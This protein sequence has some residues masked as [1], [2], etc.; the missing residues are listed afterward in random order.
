MMGEMS[1]VSHLSWTSMFCTAVDEV[2]LQPLLN[3][4]QVRLCL[5]K[6]QRQ[7]AS[8]NVLHRVQILCCLTPHGGITLTAHC[9]M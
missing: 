9:F 4:I 1:S 3:V 5:Q 8:L 7:S 2:Q 6:L